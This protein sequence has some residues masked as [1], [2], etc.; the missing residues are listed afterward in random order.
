M[1]RPH[2]LPAAFLALEAR[3]PRCVEARLVAERLATKRA[4]IEARQPAAEFYG[5]EAEIAQRNRPIAGAFNLAR[6]QQNQ[7][8]HRLSDFVLRQNQL[9]DLTDDSEAGAEF[10]IALRLVERLNQFAL[11][12]ANQVARFFFDVPKLYV[13][14]D[15]ERGTVAVF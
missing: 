5:P 14:K 4:A 1:Q 3:F 7:A 8:K 11:L 10:V 9:G 15:L 12:N 6:D 13:R 2:S